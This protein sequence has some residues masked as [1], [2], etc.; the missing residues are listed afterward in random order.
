[1]NS[2]APQLGKLNDVVG[3]IVMILIPLAG[4]ACIVMI[5]V[6]GFNYLSAGGDKEGAARAQKTLTYAISGL[7]LTI[8]AWLILDL[9]GKFIGI[10][11]GQFNIC[12]PGQTC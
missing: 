8:S 9:F 10:T 6:G 1:M 11:I 2:S 3:N 5:V 12:F 7:I 4:F